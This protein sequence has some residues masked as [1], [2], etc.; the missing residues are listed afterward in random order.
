MKQLRVMKLLE[1]FNEFDL[2]RS[3]HIEAAELLELGKARQT[4]GQKSREWTEEKNARLVNKMDTNSDGKI[5][6]CEF[7]EYFEG[8]LPQQED[9]FEATVVDFM[10]V[11]RACRR[12]KLDNRSA[13]SDKEEADK[14]EELTRYHKVC[15]LLEE[16]EALLE[17]DKEVPEEER[18][19]KE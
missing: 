6:G 19:F 8:A 1:V 15:T 11:A 12:R 14:E 7:A 4:L 2:D 13:L 5:A 18:I 17:E 3:G 10:A 9:E 16:R